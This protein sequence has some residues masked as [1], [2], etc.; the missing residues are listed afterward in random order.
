MA[1]HVAVYE[2]LVQWAISGCALLAVVALVLLAIRQPARRIR[3]IETALVGLLALPLLALIPGYPRVVMF[4]TGPRDVAGDVDDVNDGVVTGVPLESAPL[5][6][7]DPPAEPGAF[8]AGEIPI[9]VADA[10]PDVPVAEGFVAPAVEPAR[11]ESD[12][13]PWPRDWRLWIAVG[14]LAGAGAMIGWSCVGMLAVARLIRAARPANDAAK[15][16]LSEIAGRGHR[17][18]A[19]LVSANVE[20]PCV[21]V[22]RRPTIVLPA[23]LAAAD[24]ARQL[25]YALTHEWSHVARGDAL[26]WA[27]SSA[28][29]WF[30]FYQP[31][32]LPLRRQLRLCQDYLADAAAAQRST[33]NEDYAEFLTKYASGLRQPPL[34]HGLGM[35]GRRSDLERRI[36]MLV[37]NR[38][39]L[40]RAVPRRWNVVALLLAGLLVAAVA[41]LGPRAVS[42]A[43]EPPAGGEDEM[44]AGTPRSESEASELPESPGQPDVSPTAES[45]AEPK[46]AAGIGA[47]QRRSSGDGFGANPKRSPRSTSQ[48]QPGVAAPPHVEAAMQKD[49][50]IQQLSGRLEELF[51]QLAE[52]TSEKQLQQFQTRFEMLL[53]AI[54][55]R[56]ALL[57]PQLLD[58][59][60]SPPF[61]AW[62]RRAGA[63]SEP[64]RGRLRP[65]D[66]LKIDLAGGFPN[67]R[68]TATVEPDGRLALGAQFGRVNVA[69]KSLSEAEEI[70]QAKLR[71]ILKDPQV[72]LTYDGHDSGVAPAQPGFGAMRQAVPK[73]PSAGFA[74]APSTIATY[75]ASQQ[76]PTSEDAGGA[77]YPA[78]RLLSQGDISQAEHDKRVQLEEQNV[79]ILDLWKLTDELRKKL[80]YENKALRKTNVDLSRQLQQLSETLEEN[81]PPQTLESGPSSPSKPSDE[82]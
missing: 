75:P 54:E 43:D 59:L 49:R 65:G 37:D 62:P 71:G 8:V 77:V 24:D 4:S 35:A 29:R 47:S 53:A 3:V 69:G 34:A 38:R 57:R 52:T 61:A 16:V 45:Q 21:L 11:A 31:L 68:T 19:L 28:A 48:P 51:L 64:F 25:R 41:T 10:W 40:E 73:K 9:D 55:A 33:S 22:W 78:Q 60:A 1:W 42:G 46:V 63:A 74:T 56:K 30:C 15:A 44:V 70:I 32:L 76:P 27:L 82:F 81:K 66:I 79:R 2:A 39:M 67:G 80:L 12:F 20:Q 13:W 14:Y 26:A 18:V 50:V 36:V 6:S 7:E 23:H 5:E 17:P 72:Q 58:R